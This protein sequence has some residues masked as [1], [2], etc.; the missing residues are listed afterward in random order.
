ME[1]A[2][3]L[4]ALLVVLFC[5]TIDEFHQCFV[6]ARTASIVDVGIDI[7]GGILAPF[8]IAIVYQYRKE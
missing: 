7:A 5:A 6:P 4:G 1:L 2:L 8:V 3:V